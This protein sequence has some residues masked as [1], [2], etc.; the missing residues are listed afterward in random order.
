MPGSMQQYL[1]QCTL[2]LNDGEGSRA[3]S[4]QCGS[5]VM[6]CAPNAK[7]FTE[8][9]EKSF[10][11]KNPVRRKSEIQERGVGREVKGWIEGKGVPLMVA[12]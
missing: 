3:G 12:P 7:N 10:T 2:S 4:C 1:S 8:A 6:F 5:F 9:S 11:P